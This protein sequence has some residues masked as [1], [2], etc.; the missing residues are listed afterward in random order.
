MY[1]DKRILKIKLFSK[2]KNVPL[3]QIHFLLK[4]NNKI[5]DNLHIWFIIYIIVIENLDNYSRYI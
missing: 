3:V 2:G 5:L 1:E 4:S